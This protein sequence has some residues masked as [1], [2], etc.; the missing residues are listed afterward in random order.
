ML[1]IFPNLS[2]SQNTST[3]FQA[4]ALRGEIGPEVSLRKIKD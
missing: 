1:G 2:F 4:T 3:E